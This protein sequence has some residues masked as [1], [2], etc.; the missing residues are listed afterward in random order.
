M[1]RYIGG[2]RWGW[3]RLGIPPPE[4][5]PAHRGGLSGHGAILLRIMGGSRRA[6]RS[7]IS[8]K[9]ATADRQALTVNYAED[10]ERCQAVVAGLLEEYEAYLD[11]EHELC[12]GCPVER[13]GCF[14]AYSMLDWKAVYAGGRL[15][16]WTRGD[17]HEYLFEH[18][19]RKVSADDQLVRDTP[20]CVRDLMYFLSDRGTLAGDDLDVLAGAADQVAED[21]AR[22][23]RDPSNW[24]LAKATFM[25]AGA[26]TAPDQPTMTTGVD[27]AP[28]A[29]RQA[30][31]KAAATRRRKRRAVSAARKRS[32]R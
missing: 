26:M 19:P 13:S 15:Y 4:R 22:A 23:N 24:G 29:P 25:R 9:G 12:P 20:T 11:R 28:P 3:S 16:H 8:Q 31:T 21:F 18:F 1:H 30:R 17:I 7:E 2:W 27:R 6:M 32:R 14:V 10:P 5:G